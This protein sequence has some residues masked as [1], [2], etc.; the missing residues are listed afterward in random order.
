VQVQVELPQL[1]DWLTGA[2]QVQLKIEDIVSIR[3]R[4]KVEKHL[5]SA[6]RAGVAGASRR[7]GNGDVLSDLLGGNDAMSTT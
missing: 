4:G 5:L 3:R 7:L 6:A 1:K 2:P